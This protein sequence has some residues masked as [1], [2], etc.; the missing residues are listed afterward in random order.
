[1][2]KSSP[3]ILLLS[4]VLAA[5]SATYNPQSVE[6][7]DY[8]VKQQ[9]VTDSTL[10]KLIAPYAASLSTTMNEVIA[11]VGVR[12]EKKQPEGTLGNVIADA[13]LQS[14][15]KQFGQ[16]VDVA[17][18]NYGGVRLNEIPAGPLTRGKLFELSPFDNTIVL[19]TLSG[20]VMKQLLDHI[21]TAG[22]WPVAGLRMQIADKKATQGMINGK[23]LDLNAKYTIALPDY[24]ANGG[25][26]TTMLKAL[27]RQDRG[28]L[29][30]DE[31]QAYFTQL[32]KEGKSIT[33]SIE[34]RITGN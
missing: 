9:P 20:D 19:M 24:V 30:R 23:P 27:P 2:K 4:I 3:I 15:R 21:A 32:Q 8:R 12:L 7:A 18:M 22:G 34:G 29:L 10:L 14:A 16:P 25:D 13:M 11:N 5:C 28:I 17:I 1:M 6:Y 33:S 31:L 26:N